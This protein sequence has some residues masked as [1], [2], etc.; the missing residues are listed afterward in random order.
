MRPDTEQGVYADSPW[1]Y[2]QVHLGYNY[3]MS[4]VHA[5]LELSQMRRLSEFSARRKQ[6][7][8]RYDEKLLNLPFALPAQKDY[9]QSA[10]HLYP[11][12]VSESADVELVR[13]NLY[14]FLNNNGLGINVHYIPVHTQPYYQKLEFIKGNFTVSEHH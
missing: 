5:A 11:I 12:L 14:K 1:M 3:R 4:D 8:Q 10:L 6:I 2:E 13:L 9:G 7:A